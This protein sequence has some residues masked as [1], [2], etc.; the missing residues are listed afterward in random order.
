MDDYHKKINKLKTPIDI[1]A[2]QNEQDDSISNS[3]T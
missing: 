3:A 1:L 2:T